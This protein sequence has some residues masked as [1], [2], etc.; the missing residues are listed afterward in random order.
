MSEAEARFEI[1][2]IATG[3]VRD[4]EGNLVNTVQGMETW[5]VSAAELASFTDDVL[6]SAGLTDDQIAE[7]RTATDRGVT[8]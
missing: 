7:V 8:R 5:Q 4:A 3:E 1:Q 6:R 2:A